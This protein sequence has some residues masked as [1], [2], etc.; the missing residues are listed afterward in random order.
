MNA[1]RVGAAS[2]RR[3]LTDLLLLTG[4]QRSN[5]IDCKQSC[6]HFGLLTDGESQTSFSSSR[7][8]SHPFMLHY[9]SIHSDP[10]RHFSR[11]AERGQK[12]PGNTHTYMT[13]T[14]TPTPPSVQNNRPIFQRYFS[15]VSSGQQFVFTSAA[16]CQLSKQQERLSSQWI[17]L[18]HQPSASKQQVGSYIML[19]RYNTPVRRYL[20]T[21]KQTSNTSFFFF[22][23]NTPWFSYWTIYD[24]L[25]ERL[26]LTHLQLL[27]NFE[28][29]CTQLDVFLFL[30]LFNQLVSYCSFWM[31]DVPWAWFKMNEDR[32]FLVLAAELLPLAENFANFS[33]NSL[34]FPCLLF[35]TI[36]FCCSSWYY[37]SFLYSFLFCLSCYYHTCCF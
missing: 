6:F 28:M 17:L 3:T 11:Q 29:L 4:S 16:L 14:P 32:V 15:S 24:A 7:R 20:E 10:G 9:L 22:F 13:N 18:L 26:Y 1:P 21:V 31:L 35:C 27:D 37:F 5:L 12:G 25:L 19:S 33:S 8:W 36:W 30:H 23:L 2:A 34:I